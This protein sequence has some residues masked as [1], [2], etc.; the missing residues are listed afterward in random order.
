[1]IDKNTYGAGT[2][3]PLQRLSRL[4]VPPTFL[5]FSSKTSPQSVACRPST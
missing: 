3:I 1:M 4:L 2:T 5:T